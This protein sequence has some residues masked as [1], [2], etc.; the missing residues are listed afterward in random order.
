MVWSFCQGHK[1][2]AMLVSAVYVHSGLFFEKVPQVSS[3]H[4]GLLVKRIANLVTTI[5]VTDIS[6]RL[7]PLRIVVLGMFQLS[8]IKYTGRERDQYFKFFSGMA[9]TSLTFSFLKVNMTSK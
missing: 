8:L 4:T 7:E 9:N 1:K 5:V 2:V 6:N 3:R